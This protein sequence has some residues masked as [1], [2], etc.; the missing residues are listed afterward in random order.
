MLRTFNACLVV[1]VLVVAFILYSLEHSIRKTEREIA[2]L[3]SRISYERETIKLLSAEWNSLTRPERLQK[4]AEEH[5]GLKTTSADQF[6]SR[7]EIAVRVPAEPYVRL[8]EKGKD[9]IGDILKAME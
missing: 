8:E 5:L 1:T 9:A 7:A 4:L 3:D 6:I 2:R